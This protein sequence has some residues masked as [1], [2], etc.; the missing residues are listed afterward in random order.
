MKNFLVFIFSLNFINCFAQDKDNIFLKNNNND[1]PSKNKFIKPILPKQNSDY[2]TQENLDDNL[3]YV[4][5]GYINNKTAYDDTKF[6][7][8]NN[9]DE[10][11][12][13][14][15]NTNSIQEEK[16]ILISN[17]NNIAIQNLNENNL[18]KNF[19]GFSIGINF[20][21]KNDITTHRYDDGA[22]Y[23]NF[24]YGGQSNISS[25]TFDYGYQLNKF[26]TLLGVKV[27]NKSNIYTYSNGYYS[28]SSYN[29]SYAI[30]EKTHN[31]FFFAPGYLIS[32]DTLLFFKLNY[33]IIKYQQSYS[34]IIYSSDVAKS[35]GYGIGVRSKLV[36]NWYVNLEITK[37]KYYLNNS[38][39]YY[40]YSDSSSSVILNTTIG[41]IGLFYKF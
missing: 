34:N 40:Y 36:D 12:N 13:S 1:F 23:D 17:S 28:D 14:V 15:K 22:Y 30:K 24:S 39:Y 8:L 7:T 26:V 37:N 29:Y 4:S 16:I 11:N 9:L 5:N 38:D 6:E 33:D 10:N 35:K 18:S 3:G 20:D 19:K 2:T 31:S 27:Y 41:S 21:M 25:I 32:R